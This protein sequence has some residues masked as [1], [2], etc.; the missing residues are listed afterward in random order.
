M[1]GTRTLLFG[2]AV[3]LFGAGPLLLYVLLGPADGNPIGLGLLAMV[4]VP[5]GLG[6]AGLGLVRMLIELLVRRSA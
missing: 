2:L 6:C 1:P 5:V 3:L 4:A